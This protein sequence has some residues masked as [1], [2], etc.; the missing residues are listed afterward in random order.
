MEGWRYVRRRGPLVVL[1]S[2]DASTGS[3]RVPITKFAVS[4][5]FMS[6]ELALGRNASVTYGTAEKVAPGASIYK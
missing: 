4:V 6:A 2:S 5:Q 3:I 1:L